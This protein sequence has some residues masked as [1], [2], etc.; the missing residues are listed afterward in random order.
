MGTALRT[1][2]CTL[3][4]L[5]TMAIVIL[6]ITS[7]YSSTDNT[8][9]SVRTEQNNVRN[10]Q[11]NISPEQPNK[12]EELSESS[13]YVICD[14]EYIRA[15]YLGIGNSFGYVTLDVKLENKT[16]GE[17]TVVPLDSSVDDNMVQFV[18]GIPA[19]MMGHKSVS[20]AWLIGSEPQSNV[21]FKLGILDE[22]W[23]ELTTTDII[24]IEK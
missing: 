6:F 8:S 22:H 5:V 20:Q 17:I 19:T 3:A 23:S 11:N 18:S 9:V 14:N 7:I 4:T 10:E 13:E 21:E 24:R 16:D 15:T 2:V 1:V 12:K